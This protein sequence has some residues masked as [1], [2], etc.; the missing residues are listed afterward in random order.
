[1]KNKSIP[2][3]DKNGKVSILNEPITKRDYFSIEI[4]KQI[5]GTDYYEKGVERAVKLADQLIK[6]LNK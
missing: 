6:E 1:M 2:I 3:I 4:L 5:L